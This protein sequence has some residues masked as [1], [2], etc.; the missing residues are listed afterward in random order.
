ML[1]ENT[2]SSIREQEILTSLEVIN[3]LIYYM[4]STPSE[5][6]IS[7]QTIPK[8]Q[9]WVMVEYNDSKRA[10]FSTQNMS[11]IKKKT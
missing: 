6:D 9:R 2:H 4:S 3:M 10:Q 7:G 5:K 8:K 11:Q 1:D